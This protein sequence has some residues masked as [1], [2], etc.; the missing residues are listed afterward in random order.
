MEGG[1]VS[2]M[3]D[4]GTDPKLIGFSPL[5]TLA[6]TAGLLRRHQD[7]HAGSEPRKL[8]RPGGTF[9]VDLV[10]GKLLQTVHGISLIQ[11]CSSL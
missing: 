7:H 8:T 5:R 3:A 11:V 2:T 9:S 1:L 4:D 10:N 6:R